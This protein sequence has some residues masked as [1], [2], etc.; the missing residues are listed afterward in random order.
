MQ[1]KKFITLYIL[2]LSTL[3]SCAHADK[4]L[5]WNAEV[6]TIEDSHY[7]LRSQMND[8]LYQAMEGRHVK[9]SNRVI[10]TKKEAIELGKSV[11]L[12]EFSKDD[13]VEERR[14][15]VH[16]IKGFWIVKGL[17]PHGFTGGTLV[18]VIDSESGELF[19]TQVWK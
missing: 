13:T 19:Y 1:N 8:S 9:R 12:K 14:Y 17:L 5:T 6:N 11:F 4:G 18:T 10:K 15:M 3:M 2:C 16:L 7:F